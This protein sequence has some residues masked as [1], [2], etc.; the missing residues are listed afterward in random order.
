MKNITLQL[1]ELL[2][3]SCVK[4]IETALKKQD[5][6]EDVDILFNSSKAKV[7]FDESKLD[8]KEIAKLIT[9]IGY[10]VTSIK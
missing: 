4:K 6:I 7:K 9:A 3:P 10:E 5:G 1:E 2:C 8:S